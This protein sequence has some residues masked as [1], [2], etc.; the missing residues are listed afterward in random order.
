MFIEDGVVVGR[1]FVVKTLLEIR[2]GDETDCPG[3]KKDPLKK[4]MS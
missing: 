3:Q 1:G 2:L 4:S